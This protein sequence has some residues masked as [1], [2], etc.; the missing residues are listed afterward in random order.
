MTYSVS[1]IVGKLG[2]VRKKS[3][4]QSPFL[5]LPMKLLTCLPLLRLL[6]GWIWICMRLD[7]MFVWHQRT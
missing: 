3:H 2:G 7:G 1:D 4:I 6:N 5:L